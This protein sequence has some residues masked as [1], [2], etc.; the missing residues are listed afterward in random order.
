MLSGSFAF[1]D[2]IV[3]IELNFV[4]NNPGS[5]NSESV[6]VHY[7]FS[8]M[9]LDGGNHSGS[10]TANQQTHQVL[11]AAKVKKSDKRINP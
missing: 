7:C 6:R 10:T 2:E 5:F 1:K 3:H 8:A 4:L 11:T 9:M